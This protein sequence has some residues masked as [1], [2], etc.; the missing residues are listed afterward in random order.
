MAKLSAEAK[1]GVFVVIGLILLGLLTMRVGKLSFQRGKSY[2]L[3][4]YFDTATGL[5]KDAPVEIAGVEI[6]RIRKILLDKG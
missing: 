1:V 2:R 5:A 6:G 4:A 3:Q